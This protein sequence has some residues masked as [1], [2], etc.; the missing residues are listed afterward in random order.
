MSNT[1]LYFACAFITAF[2]A[3]LLVRAV[4]KKID[5]SVEIVCAKIESVNAASDNRDGFCVAQNAKADEKVE[6][7]NVGKS[8]GSSPE[9]TRR[10]GGQ[11]PQQGE[12]TFGRGE[13]ERPQVGATAA[14]SPKIGDGGKA[15]AEEKA[16]G[17]SGATANNFVKHIKTA[18]K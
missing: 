17:G 3:L 8:G 13:Q 2:H 5:E 14:Q 11:F 10:I 15:L 1:G 18:A 12:Q 4:G 16:K 9:R 7:G 6:F